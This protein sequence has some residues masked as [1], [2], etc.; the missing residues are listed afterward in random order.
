M[1]YDYRDDHRQRRGSDQR[2]HR[3]DEQPRGGDDRGHEPRQSGRD[4]LKRDRDDELWGS[5]HAYGGNLESDWGQHR[6]SGRADEAFG[7]DFGRVGDGQR[8]YRD[9]T[10]GQGNYGQDRY[11][12]G[13]HPI[14]VRSSRAKNA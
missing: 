6:R 10:Y 9:G 5:R 8:N 13:G 14:G 2:Q 4:E 1:A 11:I 7:S 12:G 3:E